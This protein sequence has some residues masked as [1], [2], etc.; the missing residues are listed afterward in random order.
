[1]DTK[2][3]FIKLEDRWELPDSKK[4]V[5]NKK[6]SE[7]L[8]DVSAKIKLDKCLLCNKPCTSFCNSHTIPRF[9]I[10]ESSKNGE[11]FYSNTFLKNPLLR[12]K[13]GTNN[14]ITF[15][16]ICNECDKIWFKDYECYNSY[17]EEPTQKIIAEI[18][19]KN[20]LRLIE[21]KRRE[22]SACLKLYEQTKEIGLLNRLEQISLCISEI[23]QSIKLAINT[24]NR[25]KDGYYLIDYLKLN[26]PSKMI[27]QGKIALTTGFDNEIINEI[28]SNDKK[29]KIQYLNF[30]VF[31]IDGKANIIM[32]IEDGD[33]RY[34]KFYK[35]YRKLSLKE[36]LKVINFIILRDSDEWLLSTK[37][38]PLLLNNKNVIEVI[39]TTN[40][41]KP[42]LGLSKDE[43]KVRDD[44]LKT[45]IKIFTL[46]NIPD[47]P[48]FLEN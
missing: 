3:L 31:N 47:I 46:S 39:K 23:E 36:K 8:K 29:Y 35:K 45:A 11:C 20:N 19:L 25:K 16:C 43:Q 12:I 18:A 34:S 37:V 22:Q 7:F 24:I 1:M 42:I 26:Y 48:N 13:L 32:F 6:Y 2:D 21:V 17:N 30:A 40:E 4:I 10:E 9:I 28:Y 5:L 27:F 41:V 14:A 33:R 44:I 38:D 15:H